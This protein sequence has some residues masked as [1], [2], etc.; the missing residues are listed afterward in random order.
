MEVLNSLENNK[1]K[2]R[3]QKMPQTLR[4]VHAPQSERVSAR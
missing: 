1:K 4:A 2:K 3:R